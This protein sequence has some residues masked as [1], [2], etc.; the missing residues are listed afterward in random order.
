MTEAE[1]TTMPVAHKDSRIRQR[2]AD[3]CR[4]QAQTLRSELA[5]YASEFWA[6]EAVLIRRAIDLLEKIPQRI[7]AND[8]IDRREASQNS[9]ATP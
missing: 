5:H 1:Q 2:M 7:D 8:E 3:D 6:A 9:K 4:Q